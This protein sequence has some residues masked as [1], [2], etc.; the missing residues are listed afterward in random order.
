VA[1][2]NASGTA[3][4]KFSRLPDG[5]PFGLAE[6]S[7]T[8]LAIT[9][10][11]HGD[12]VGLLGTASGGSLLGA[13]AYGPFGER[14]GATGAASGLGY[15]GEWTDPAT[16]RVNM[17]ARWYTP[18][19]GTFAGRDSWTIE[20]NPSAAANRYGYGNAAPLT[21][22]D[23]TGHKASPL[24]PV[25]TGVKIGVGFT[26]W[27]RAAKIGLGA[28]TLAGTG[29]ALW[30]W[31]SS[32]PSQGAPSSG[33]VT[34]AQ[35][36]PTCAAT[37]A[38]NA[39]FRQ[40]WAAGQAKANTFWKAYAAGAQQGAALKQAWAAGQA[41]ANTFWKAWAAGAQQGAAFKQA[42][43]EGQAKAAAFWTAW[44]AG[45]GGGLGNPWTPIRPRID[46]GRLVD[47]VARTP[48]PR[49]TPKPG[50]TQAELDGRRLAIEIKQRV[51]MSD[52]KLADITTELF[53]STDA[54]Q[55]AT[56]ATDASGAG[57]GAGNKPPT[58]LP[59]PDEEGDGDEAGGVPHGFANAEELVPR[60][61]DS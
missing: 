38:R 6:G 42:W 14:L 46:V 26:P 33:G 58:G 61:G 31:G 37:L 50:I 8:G 1:V 60:V 44:N 27:D 35:L 21:N 49:P 59:F 36:C 32:S 39:Q 11:V 40:D 56:L 15:Q 47:T 19:T 48:A 12:V 2:L 5:S 22:T 51:V 3:T 52:Q 18:E 30:M 20:P 43:A 28:G 29:L 17:H 16:S 23:P 10:L 34:G 9:D 41:R 55:G 57:G 7:A 54:R 53:V 4:S 25:V 13:A 45:T 24:A